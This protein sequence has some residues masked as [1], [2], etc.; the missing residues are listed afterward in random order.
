MKEKRWGWLRESGDLVVLARGTLKANA[1][2][3]T[4]GKKKDAIVEVTLDYKKGA[5]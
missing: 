4:K 2:K 1:M 3:I 5:K